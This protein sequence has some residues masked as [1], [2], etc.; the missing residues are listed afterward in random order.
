MHQNLLIINLKLPTPPYFY[1]EMKLRKVILEVCTCWLLLKPVLD[2]DDTCLAIK[3]G[4]FS[5]SEIRFLNLQISK[6]KYS[7]KLY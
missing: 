4:F 3:G 7:K 2:F 6:K 1:N 5:E